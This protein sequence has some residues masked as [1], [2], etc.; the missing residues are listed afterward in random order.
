MRAPSARPRYLNLARIS[1][2]VGAIASI[3][4]RISGV[5]LV[6]TLPFAVLALQRS[7]ADA[8]AFVSLAATLHSPVGRTG[9]LILAW[10]CAHHLFAGIR[11]LLMDVGVC[12]SLPAS[13]SSA[14]AVLG[15]GAAIAAAV[16]VLA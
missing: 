1:Y 2:P 6:C 9:L 5:L 7:L 14:V 8:A 4:H 15:A 3:G 16:A 13:R 10:V 12:A 11:H